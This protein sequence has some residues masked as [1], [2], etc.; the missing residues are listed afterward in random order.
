MITE[1]GLMGKI[2]VNSAGVGICLNAIRARGV[3]YGRLPV[4]LAMRASLEC[5]SRQ[6][7]IAKLEDSGVAAAVHFLIAD[8][9]GAT[10]LECSHKDIVK[11]EMQKGRICHSNHFLVEHTEGIFDTVFSRDSLD[12]MA[13]ATELLEKAAESEKPP[14][15][16]TMEKM[17][18]DEKGYPGAIS[19]AASSK[20]ANATLFGV[21]MDLNAKMAKVRIGRPTQC[22]G[23]V[24]LEPLGLQ[25]L[26]SV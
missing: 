21:V 18:E 10:S 9:T 25:R 20:S 3:D 5:T 19:R 8:G 11:M 26:D 1:A 22:K 17:L 14:T 13:R 4:H 2:G 23:I 16:L 7:A 12:R 24:F 6:E 15:M